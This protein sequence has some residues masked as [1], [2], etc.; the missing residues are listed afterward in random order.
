MI[1][2]EQIAHRFGF[3]KASIEGVNATAPIH[4]FLREMYANLAELV[5]INVPDGREKVLAFDRLEEAAMWSHK[6]VA[7]QNPLDKTS[8]RLLS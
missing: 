1:G 4:A 6:A 2:K 5:D 7:K 3:H 8:E